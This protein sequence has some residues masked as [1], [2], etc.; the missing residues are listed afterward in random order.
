LEYQYKYNG[1]EWQDE[2]GLNFYDYGARNCDPALGRWMNIDPL[3]E[4][5]PY[6]NPYMY[7]NNNPLIYADPDGQDGVI[8]I[9]GNQINISANIQLYGSGATKSVA[10]QMQKSINNKWGGNFTAKSS[11]GTN[12]NVNV[13]ATVSLYGGKEK[14]NPFLI[15]ES[16]NSDNRD[17]FIEIGSD[18]KRSYVT[19]G[20]EGEWR[21]KGRNGQT[22][23][24]DDPAPHEFGHLLG[25]DDRYTDDKGADK[26]WEN[27]I[28][29]DSKNGKVEQINIDA[30]LEDAMK[31]YDVWSQD[32]NNKGKEFRYEI[33]ISRPNKEKDE[34]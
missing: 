11:N 34:N 15:P 33:N 1:K 10:N 32:E 31:A 8:V 21:G 26:G 30:I 4:K 5:H 16:W 2:L 29:G 14:S 6:N 9:K 28:M 22:L 20:D 27:N 7:V 25:L 17:N 23:A 18:T 13:K 24:Q 3:A 19:G 12:F